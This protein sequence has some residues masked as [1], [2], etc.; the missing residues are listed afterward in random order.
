MIRILG[1]VKVPKSLIIL[2]AV[3]NAAYDLGIS[4]TLTSGNDSTHMPG[5]KHYT[6]EALDFRTHGY[7]L[8]RSTQWK[9]L[10]L[11]RLG[12][13]YQGWVEHPGLP[14]EHMHIEYDPS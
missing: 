12:A 7:D 10:S 6:D 11:Q 8:A 13:A 2:A 4:V 1:S 9:T 3:T 14:N 5:S